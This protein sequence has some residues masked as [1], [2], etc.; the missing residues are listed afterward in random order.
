[1]ISCNASVKTLL[2]PSLLSEN[3]RIR[4]YR[5][6]ILLVVLDVRKL[7]SLTLREEH[8]LR[9]FVNR[10]LRLI[11]GSKRDEVSAGWR[12]LHNEEHRDLY[13]LPSIIRMIK[14][15]RMKWARHVAQIERKACMLLVGKPER[16]RPL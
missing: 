2:C 3:V 12:K 11:F 1:M 5:I 6:I 7:G 14:S 16:K 9:V 13:P 10:V 8:A 4:I 15:R